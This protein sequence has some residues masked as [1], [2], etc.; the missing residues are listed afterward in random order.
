MPSLRHPGRVLIVV[1]A[2][3]ALN[4]LPIALPGGALLPLGVLLSMPL[5]LTLPGPWAI[6]AAA[7]PAAVTIGVLGHPF[8]LVL[9]TLEAAWLVVGRRFRKVGPLVQD[10]VFWMGVGLPVT[11]GLTWKLGGYT[12]EI[13]TIIAIKNV[14]SQLL[15]VAIAVF[16]VRQSRFTD[17]LEDRMPKRTKIRESVFRTVFLLAV[18]PL[19]FVGVI[20]AVLIR[21]YCERSDREVLFESSQRIARQLE[22]FLRTHESAV[23]SAAGVLSR[24]G[25]DAS[26]LLQELRRTHPA[27]ITM[28][29]ADAE[30]R[31][32]QTAA[33][34]PQSGLR[35][36]KVDDRE[37]FRAAR[38]LDRP[39]VSGV[40]RG[41]GFGRD[42]LVAISAPVH[43][44]EGRFAGIVQ[45]SVEVHRFAKLVA[46]DSQIKDV[47]LLLV[48]SRGRVIYADRETGVPP[49]SDLRHF[50]QGRLLGSETEGK[51]LVFEHTDGM[52]SRAVY[53][54]HVAHSRGG[55]TVVAQRPMFAGLDGIAGA[56][57]LIGLLTLVIGVMATLVA[58]AIQ[59]GVAAPLE[60]FAR[61]ATR[62]AALR[63]VEPIENTTP[64][65]PQEIAMVYS[66]FNN[67]A[68]KL[69]GTYEMLRQQNADLDHRVVERTK[70]LDTARAQAVAAS[71]S[72]SAFLAMTSHEIRTP[73]NAI[74]GL[75]DALEEG[76]ADATTATRLRTIRNSGRRLLNVVN[77]LLDL[78]RVEAGKM[79]LHVGPTDLG[80][81]GAELDGLFTLSAE[82]HGLALRFEFAGGGAY[83][84]ET[85]G[86]RLQQVLVNLIGNALKFTR[87]GGVVVRVEEQEVAGD[88][89]YLRFSV[90]DTGPG[91]SVEQQA[92]LFQPY[93]QLGGGETAAMPGSGLGLAISKRLVGLL[94]GGLA[95]RSQVARGADFFFTLK[96]RR[97]AA[98]AA[99][100]RETTPKPVASVR[101]IR[102]L[103][104]DDNEANR[105]VLR[106]ILET[107][108]ARLAVVDSAA[109]AI[110]LL[111]R[112]PFDVALIDLE[113]GDADGL[114]VARTV[115]EW[116]H[117]EASL[118]CR[119]V[120]FSAH[121]RD[122]V[123]ARCNEA[124]FDD[125][126][127][128][129]I[130]R[131]ALRRV[132][133]ATQ[134]L[135]AVG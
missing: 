18:V 7:V 40:F 83:W 76:A 78:S 34:G 70:E 122:E 51:P 43:D 8:L 128:K 80:A 16:L 33:D 118:G 91:I 111:R 9:L 98:P 79:E 50:V 119:L 48:D 130:D 103:A 126:V 65:A 23:S 124:G 94:G 58:R 131:T 86:A 62:Q 17:W 25:G 133:G 57:L 110:D 60:I 1:L 112:M 47:E 41:R 55:V 82:E 105:E 28:L 100:L 21:V 6:L 36:S 90:A 115:R 121:P 108:C 59:Q 107:Q 89:V 114:T 74:I 30:G 123:W 134:P 127:E 11:I 32:I 66:A 68:V 61:N 77:D 135:A 97:C 44:A 22:L 42:I 38:D 27:F 84:I 5:V 73:L 95:V 67:L 15:A 101:E 113:M 14:V 10:M 4:L 102:I 26:I 132:L 85:D 29:V 13:V 49:L 69:H 20:S 81:M 92:R 93:V 56:F 19:A 63:T 120:A 109:A 117:D 45:A 106:S 129:P 125:Y 64:E 3:M 46:E 35:F 116:R 104:A 88:C 96:V 12:P 31:I 37:Y 99:P 53:V 87:A 72:K 52:G 75:A 71:E 54:A 39:Y 24:G 2:A